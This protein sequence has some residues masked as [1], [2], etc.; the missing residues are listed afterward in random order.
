MTLA[1]KRKLASGIFL[2]ALVALIF[3]VKYYHFDDQFS[4][5]YTE[6]FGDKLDRTLKKAAGDN[7]MECSRVYIE[8]RVPTESRCAESADSEHHNFYASYAVSGQDGITYRG[9][10]RNASGAYTEY[11]WNPGDKAT[12]IFGGPDPTPVTCVQALH[13]TWL[14]IATCTAEQ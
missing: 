14:G 9:I 2:L 5:M 3:S 13:R 7:A 8:K 4:G 1:G 6:R 11:T 12:A 10:V